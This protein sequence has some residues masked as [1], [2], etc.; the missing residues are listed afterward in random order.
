M[1]SL[2]EAYGRR[3]GDEDRRGPLLV[4]AATFGLGV[5]AILGGIVLVTLEPGGEVPARRL[6]G[7]LGG[8]GLP[9]VF[10]GVVA[11]IPAHRTERALTAVGAGVCGV[12]TAWFY[13]AYPEHWFGLT[14]GDV[15]LEVSL[16][17]LAGA[18]LALWYVMGAV[19]TFKTRND[20]HGTVTLEI[21]RGEKTR[22]VEVDPREVDRESLRRRVEE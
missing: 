14:P 2:G 4:G 20:P 12:A 10:L 11:I 13:R 22:V 19:A 17:Y 6:A 9:L 21:T 18:A 7:L 8:V 15:T 3:R 1:P 16:L 5:A